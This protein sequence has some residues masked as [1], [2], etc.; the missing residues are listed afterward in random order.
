MIVLSVLVPLFV[1]YVVVVLLLYIYRRIYWKRR[2][3][4][5][6]IIIPKELPT[7]GDQLL[8]ESETT[9]D[10]NA[11][12]RRESTQV[13]EL[14]YTRP[15][16]G[17]IKQMIP[18]ANA[19]PQPRYHTIKRAQRI[20]KMRSNQ[21]KE[22]LNASQVYSRNTSPHSQY[23]STV[24]SRQSLLSRS[25]KASRGSTQTLTNGSLYSGIR[26]SLRSMS[27]V[28]LSVY[29]L[30][31]R[32]ETK[33]PVSSGVGFDEDKNISPDPETNNQTRNYTVSGISKASTNRVFPASQNQ[34]A[35]TQPQFPSLYD[36]VMAEG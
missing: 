34:N 8:A 27:S 30:F 4:R 11:A 6:T 33:L 13:P 35:R 36:F 18:N 31:S 5:K 16:E 7:R 2:K 12:I 20:D 25:N 14:T 10:V 29:S 19:R 32:Q 3:Q 24:I 9:T 28:R 23:Q 26:P 22:M 15:T 21:F 1:L 17:G